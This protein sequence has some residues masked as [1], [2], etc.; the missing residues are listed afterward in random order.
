MRVVSNT[1]PISNLAIIG[2]LDVL[3]RQFETI[4]IPGAVRRE[5]ARLEHQAGSQSIKQALSQGWIQVEAETASDLARNLASSLDAGEA[6]AIA[7]ASQSAADLLIMDESAGR[8]AARNLGITM[9]GTLGVLLK[10][11]RAGRLSSIREEMDRLVADA[12]FFISG[13]VRQSFLEAA[14]E[15]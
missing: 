13:S 7:L 8:A 1:S 15:D 10:E 5:L 14:G 9:T 2:R 12:G 3:L 4:R 11:K 6:E